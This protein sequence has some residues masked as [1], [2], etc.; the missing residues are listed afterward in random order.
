MA[1][2]PIYKPCVPLWSK[3]RPE[4]KD[5]DLSG[6]TVITQKPKKCVATCLA[7]LTKQTPEMFDDVDKDDPYSWDLAVKPFNLTLIQ[8]N[9]QPVALIHYIE[10]LEQLNSVFL[11]GLYT[12]DKPSKIIAPLNK[13]GT[14]GSSH[15]VLLNQHDV[16]D[17]CGKIYKLC[18]IKNMHV[19]RIFRVILNN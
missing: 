6:V 4:V 9:T 15:L 7:M 13:N 19:K 16:Y 12:G 5:C 14:N 11:I 17:P 18:D 3:Y 2:I 10:E 1:E 8:C